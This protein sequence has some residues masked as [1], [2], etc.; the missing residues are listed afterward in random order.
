MSR[1]VFGTDSIT[2]RRVSAGY[3]LVFPPPC[4]SSDRDHGARLT[5][6]SRHR[7]FNWF[8][9]GFPVKD[10]HVDIDS[11]TTSVAGLVACRRRAFGHLHLGRATD[12]RNITAGPL[13]AE[14]A[15]CLIGDTGQD[16]TTCLRE[17]GELA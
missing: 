7:F 13:Q 4:P 3:R 9:A 8:V 11:S 12:E 14:R 2:H 5:Q 1:A 17:A 15:A 16:R 6:F 10:A